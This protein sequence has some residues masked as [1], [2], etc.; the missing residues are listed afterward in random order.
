MPLDLRH[1]IREVPDFPQQG[2]VFR[3]IMPLLRSREAFAFAVDALAEPFRGRADLVVAPESRGFI[4]GGALARELGAG[5]IAI[6]KPG[7]L[8]GATA[9]AAYALE[10]GEDQLHLQQGA[11]APGQKVLLVD[12]VLATGGTARAVQ[13]LVEQQGGRIMGWAFLIELPRLGGRMGLKEPVHA[14][15][16]Y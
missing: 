14:L 15:L 6:R 5:F 11:L 1:F 3:D 10:Y 12:D 16:R 7:K 4:L 9:S 2:V 13:R 8:P